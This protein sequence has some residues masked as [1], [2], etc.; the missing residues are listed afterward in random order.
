MADINAV[1]AALILEDSQITDGEEIKLPT[2]MQWEQ[3]VGLII[4]NKANWSHAGT[5]LNGEDP[6]S[7]HE[8]MT[9]LT[10]DKI[11]TG[12]H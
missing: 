6:T 2:S 10:L 8:D 5:I 7:V 9:S 1:E 11:L 3:V 4:N 12:I